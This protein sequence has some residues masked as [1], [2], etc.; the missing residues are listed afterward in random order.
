MLHPD[1]TFTICPGAPDNGDDGD[2]AAAQPVADGLTATLVFKAKSC[3]HWIEYTRRYMA[4]RQ[5]D[6]PAQAAEKMLE[7]ALDG[8]V[9]VRVDNSGPGDIDTPRVDADNLAEWMSVAEI[10]WIAGEK[11]AASMM[12]DREKK[13]LWSS[14]SLPT[15]S[16]DAG[17]TARA[18]A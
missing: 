6:D 15:D 13:K 5:I 14:S 4:A 12:S 9:E 16:S 2:G 18:D 17:A 3:A 11:L 8:L 1:D 7:L 10:R